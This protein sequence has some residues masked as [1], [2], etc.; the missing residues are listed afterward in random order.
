LLARYR[1]KTNVLDDESTREAR[2]IRAEAYFPS[3]ELFPSGSALSLQWIV[4]A[5]GG[6]PCREDVTTGVANRGWGARCFD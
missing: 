2:Q 3:A 6:W 4:R 5:R 1:Q